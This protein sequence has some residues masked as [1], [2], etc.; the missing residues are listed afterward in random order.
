MHEQASYDYGDCLN[1]LVMASPT[2]SSPKERAK[3]F[4]DR[5]AIQVPILVAPMAGACPASLSIAV[6]N[7]GGLGGCGVLMMTPAEIKSWATEFREQSQGHFQ[8]N[9]WIP[10]PPPVRDMEREERQREFL[11]KWGPA[12]AAEAGEATLP[13]FDAQCEAMLAAEPKAISSI[14]GIYPAAFVS[15]LKSRGI[16]W[17][18]VATTVAEAKA[19]EE[20]GADVIVAQGA[21][22]GGHRGSFR[23]GEAE[24]QMVGLLSLV[25]QVADAVRVPVVATGGIADAR[26]VKA[27]LMLGA[28]GV[29]IGTGFLRSPEAKMP[30]AYADTLSRT[31]ANDTRVTRSFSGR[32]GRSVANA[33][34][35]AAMEPGA[36][37]PAPYPVQRGLTRAMRDEARKAG[38]AERMQIWAGQSAKL[39]IAEPAAE[40][41][42]K[43]AEAIEGLP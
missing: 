21:E 33:Y 17:F 11:A 9:L 24:R 8:M 40:I 23:A 29:Q 25:P 38:D 35:R 3:D 1:P 15:E 28:S 7:A 12:V 22:A 14:M 2:N 18:A 20:A 32:P 26:G 4:A 42:A 27:A 39:A 36:P 43:L 10:D 34:V 13:D 6:A 16:L 41:V 30:A 19:A 37:A 5:L 31:E